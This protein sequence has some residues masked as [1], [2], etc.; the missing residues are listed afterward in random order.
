MHPL[1]ANFIT[2][3]KFIFGIGI[4]VLKNIFKKNYKL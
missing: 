1:L 4:A 2:K 3:T